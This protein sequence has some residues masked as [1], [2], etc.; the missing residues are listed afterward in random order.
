MPDERARLGTHRRVRVRRA[1]AKLSRRTTPTWSCSN[2]CCIRENADNKLYGN[3]GHLKSWKD[4]KAG[5]QIMVA[6][7]L[8]QK[9][10]DPSRRRRSTSTSSS[11]R[12]TCTGQPSCR[13][14][15]ESHRHRSRRSSKKR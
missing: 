5:C 4:A 3:L 11:A 13:A 15:G 14:G 9:D 2:T 8:A 6:G 10:R 7:C 1:R 12:T